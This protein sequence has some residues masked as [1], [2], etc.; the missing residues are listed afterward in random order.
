MLRLGPGEIALIIIVALVIFGPEKLPS[1]GRSLGKAMREI[2]K[3][4]R[5]VS[6]SITSAVES[7]DQDVGSEDKGGVADVR[8]DRPVG[9]SSHIDDTDADLRGETV[10]RNGTGDRAD[11]SGT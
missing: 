11:H 4:T 5:D 9:T 6:E 2:R 1:V 7:T 10:A 8:K 3:V